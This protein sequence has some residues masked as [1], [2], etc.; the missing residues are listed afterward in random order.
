LAG[1]SSVAIPNIMPYGD[2]NLRAGLACYKD[3][4]RYVRI[5]YE[6]DNGRIV[7]EIVNN[8]KK[9]SRTESQV[10]EGATSTNALR[11]C[12]EYTETEYRLFYSSESEGT[13]QCLATVDTLD[14]TDADFT[15][16]VIGVFAVAENPIEV[17]FE[18]LEID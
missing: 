6:S 15:G 18:D 9:I 7:F 12:I 14:M 3:E 11:L 10:V 17:Q 4:R 16:P 1:R 8:A 5:Y 2:V 13:W